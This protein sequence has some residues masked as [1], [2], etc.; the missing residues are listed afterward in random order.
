MVRQISEHP[1]E[2]ALVAAFD[3]DPVLAAERQARW[4]TRFGDGVRWCGSADEVLQSEIDA[5]LVEGRVFENVALAQKA[6]DAG[7][8]VLLEKPAGIDCQGFAALQSSAAACGLHVQ[9]AY[10]F[11]YMS[12]VQEM[13]RRALSGELGQIYAFRGR[14][15]KPL[16][17]YDDLVRDLGAYAG[18]V[19]FEM[20]GH[21]I[22]FCVAMLGPPRKISQTLAHHHPSQGDFIDNGV[23]V[24]ECDRG[25]GI[26]EVPAL[27]VAPAGRRIEVYG[28][29]GALVIPHL[30]SGHL[31]NNATQP[32]EIARRGR[33][34]WERL[35]I[36]AATLQISDLREFCAVI[37]GL[38]PPDF[39]RE[40]D[41]AVHA[42]LIEA[43]GMG[44]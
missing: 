2:F 15:P 24:L 29:E 40:H 35:E 22:D 19:F 32:V 8:P 3:S 39:S 31:A 34:D 21:L 26:V 44:P 25:I 7:F 4:S 41:L 28:T 14:L 42:A 6:I 13:L 18:G 16:T 36:P 20:A 12:A 1:H 38:K 37:A 30:G 10:L 43:S 27:E 11:R 23:A 17:E 33:S 9:M 5:V